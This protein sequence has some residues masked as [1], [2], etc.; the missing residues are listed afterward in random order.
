[1]TRVPLGPEWN[2][3]TILWSPD[4]RKIAFASF[5]G[6]KVLV[7][8][9]QSAERPKILFENPMFCP[10]TDWSADGR[11]L[12][13][14][15]IDWRTFNA[16]VTV[17]DLQT[18]ASRPIVQSSANDSSAVLSPD[19]RWLAYTSDESGNEEILVQRFPDG[20]DRHQISVGGGNQARWRRDGRELFYVSPDRKVMSI[21]VQ[22]GEHFEASVPRPLFQSRILP[23]VEARNHYDVTPDGQRFV[24][25]ARRRDDASLPIVVVVGWTPE[26]KKAR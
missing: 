5:P 19:G 11:L 14:D 26:A 15:A 22:P 8:N 12:F 6:G 1:M 20:S 2:S 23:P 24:V 18:G 25:N 13:Y 10:L 21:E 17:R 16:D 9:A 3:A 7:K 4:G